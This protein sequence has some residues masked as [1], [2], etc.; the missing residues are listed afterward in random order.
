MLCNKDQFLDKEV[1]E[2]GAGSIT[3]TRYY[4]MPHVD[5]LQIYNYI[6]VENIVRKGEIACNKQFLAPLALGQQAYVMVCCA[7]VRQ[8]VRLCVNVFFKDLLL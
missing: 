6:T 8:V 7:S 4:T 2:K 3:L 1:L 5:V